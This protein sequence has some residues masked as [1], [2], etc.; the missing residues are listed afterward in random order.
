M[1]DTDIEGF[2]MRKDGPIQNVDYY[3]AVSEGLFLNDGDSLD[4]RATVR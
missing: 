3:Q 4:G 1:N 2:V